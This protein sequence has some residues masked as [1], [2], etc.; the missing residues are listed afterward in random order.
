MAVGYL[1]LASCILMASPSG[2]RWP[3]AVPG[4]GVLLC[5]SLLDPSRLAIVKVDHR[6]ETLHETWEGNHGVIAVVGRGA[7]LRLKVDNQYSVGGVASREAEERQ[8]RIPLSLHPAPK[9]VFFLGMGT[10]ITAGAALETAVEKVVT[11]ELIPEVVSAA[12]KHFEPYTHGLFTDPRSTIVVNDGRNHLLGSQDTYDVIVSDLFV[13]WHAGTGSLYTIEHFRLVRS[14]LRPGGL[15]A[16]W[17]PLYQLSK[18]EFLIIARTMVEAFP[19]VTLWRGGLFSQRPIVALVGSEES[20]LD[21]SPLARPRAGL[22]GREEIGLLYAGN[23]GQGRDLLAEVPVN[24]DDR[25]LIEYLAPVTERDEKTGAASWFATAELLEFYDALFASVT[26][27]TDP[28]LRHLTPAEVA[29]VRTG[30][31]IY[32]AAFTRSTERKTRPRVPG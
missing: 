16:Q 2:R 6:T 24:T 18:Q 20:P 31:S 32:R 11:A 9:R 1:A 15:F 4:I 21:F 14:R 13:P 7:D 25:P 22:L 27:A 28:Y 23:L 17:L 19:Q 8:A 29:Y 5:F 30:L 3:C 12:R 26:P 10:G